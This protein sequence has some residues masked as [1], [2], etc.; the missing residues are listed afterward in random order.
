MK[1]E[2][3]PKSPSRGLSRRRF[4]QWTGL[5]LGGAALG[6]AFLRE[7]TA[8]Q[9]E[10]LDTPLSKA[11][12][13]TQVRVVQL[14]DTHIGQFRPYF[15]RVAEVAN[16]LQPDIILLTGDYIEE[17]RNLPAALEFLRL[18]RASAGIFA[19]QGNWE[20]WARIEGEPLRRHFKK[21]GITLLTN[22]REDV[23][24]GGME[25]SL[26]GLDY[27]S[28]ESDLLALQ[29][30]ANPERVNLL[31]SHVPAFSHEK[32]DGRIDLICCGHTHGGQVRL[33]F[34]SPLYLP[35]YTG[36]FVSGLYRVGPTATPLY[37]NRGIGTSLLPVRF[38]CRPEIT[39]FNLTGKAE[40]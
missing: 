26:L 3:T 20:Y 13:G 10:R 28:R 38:L 33:P 16:A 6:N 21:I 9:I 36:G 35:R 22:Q 5:G 11:P 23:Q 15:R 34:F 25:L 18:L 1:K 27:P 32:L 14:S 29:E 17:S 40:G 30:Q 12:A 37:V 31:L 2:K 8:L 4:L 39:L 7:P 19:V 24:A